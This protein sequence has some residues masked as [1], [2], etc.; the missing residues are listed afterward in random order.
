MASR[1]CDLVDFDPSEALNCCSPILPTQKFC[2]LFVDSEPDCLLL[3]LLLWL[4][5]CVEIGSVSV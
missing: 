1:Q 3:G 4:L 5:Y 2:Y